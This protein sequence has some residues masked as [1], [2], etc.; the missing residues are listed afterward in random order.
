[1]SVASGSISVAPGGIR[2]KPYYDGSKACLV[3]LFINVVATAVLTM[4]ADF[5]P[6]WLSVWRVPS[7]FHKLGLWW[8]CIY[9]YRDPRDYYGQVYAGCWWYFSP[10]LDAIRDQ[11]APV[12]FRVV[13]FFVTIN[14]IISL[15]AV[16]FLVFFYFTP[17][18]KWALVTVGALSAV[19]CVLMTLGCVIFAAN[20]RNEG[21]M[22]QPEQNRFD[23][24]FGFAG[25]ACFTS[26]FSAVISFIYIRW[27]TWYE[28]KI[29]DYLVIIDEQNK[30]DRVDLDGGLSEKSS[31]A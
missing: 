16:V 11:I 10:Y 4:V 21:W 2:M 9:G 6:Y 18:R 28:D 1:M 26:L 14:V 29:S 7:T 25:L 17:R 13:Q 12:W 19:S 20:G 5:A 22:P 8:F 27:L 24:A 3:T 31:T 30:R 23:W 15:L